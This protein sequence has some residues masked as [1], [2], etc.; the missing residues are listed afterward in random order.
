MFSTTRSQT[1]GIWL[2]PSRSRPD[3]LLW[4]TDHNRWR[5][6]SGLSVIGSQNWSLLCSFP[7]LFRPTSANCLTILDIVWFLCMLAPLLDGAQ[8]WLHLICSALLSAPHN[9]CLVWHPT[10]SGCVCN[11]VSISICWLVWIVSRMMTSW[12]RI[13]PLV[14]FWDEPSFISLNKMEKYRYF[15]LC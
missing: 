13:R 11:F 12:S 10:R 1:V 2:I 8:L 6:S 15:W 4:A 5:H 14:L 7:W 3:W 9:T